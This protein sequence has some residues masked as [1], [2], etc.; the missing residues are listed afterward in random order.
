MSMIFFKNYS[1]EELLIIGKQVLNLTKTGVA[2]ELLAELIAKYDEPDAENAV[3]QMA[4]RECAI[5]WLATKS[6]CAKA[7]KPVGEVPVKESY[8]DYND[9]ELRV[10]AKQVLKYYKT[11]KFDEEPLYSIAGKD[12][13]LMS[14]TFILMGILFEC[15]D[16]WIKDDLPHIDD[17]VYTK[18]TVAV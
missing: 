15:A 13:P 6:I 9:H 5:R 4:L 8:K 10:V 14:Q 1:D 17:E 16:R 11:H 18:E 3:P 2:D 12:I 7:K